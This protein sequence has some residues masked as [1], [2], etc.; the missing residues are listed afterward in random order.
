MLLGGLSHAI[1]Q[2]APTDAA[3][4]TPGGEPTALESGEVLAI[5]PDQFMVRLA[6]ESTAEQTQLYIDGWPVGLLPWSGR[7]TPGVHT[8]SVRR[9]DTGTAPRAARA[10]RGEILIQPGELKPLGPELSLSTDPAYSK[11]LLNGV[12]LSNPWTGRL[13]LGTHDLEGNHPSYPSVSQVLKVE[14]KMPREVVVYLEADALTADRRRGPR[15]L[16]LVPSFLFGTNMGSEAG[17]SC[18]VLQCSRQTAAY[19]GIGAARFGVGFASKMRFEVGAGVFYLT[20]KQRRRITDDDLPDYESVSYTLSDKLRVRGPFLSSGFAFRH[21]FGR[22]FD[23]GARLHVGVSQIFARH[24]SEGFMESESDSAGAR[25]GHSDAVQRHVLVFGWPELFASFRVSSFHF[26]AGLGAVVIMNRSARGKHGEIGPDPRMPGPC[27]D[28]Q[29]APGSSKV[30]G[31]R[32]F[33][34]SALFSFSA[35]SG[36]SF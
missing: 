14:A 17:E 13:P 4:E 33:G 24:R 20:K 29:C 15:S 30:E 34:P 9:G 1:A 11:L 35:F 12:Q 10:G 8:F 16:E 25:V 26:G 21:D 18:E 5:P 32:P 3:G 28:L 27:D 23:V 22:S 6:D 7:L 31:E 36:W 2:P 19:G